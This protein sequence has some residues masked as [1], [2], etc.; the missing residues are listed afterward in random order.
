MTDASSSSVV[1]NCDQKYEN[2]DMD[3]QIQA[4]CKIQ[5]N[6]CDRMANDLWGKIMLGFCLTGRENN[7]KDHLKLVCQV[8]L[9]FIFFEGFHAV[10]TR[11]FIGYINLIKKQIKNEESLVKFKGLKVC[12][13]DVL[14]FSNM[15]ECEFKL[16]FGDDDGN[17]I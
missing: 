16:S 3:K 2:L 15:S 12:E 1:T 13:I 14:T 4:L 7:T 17:V 9:P 10:N 8:R 5:N 6:L 11:Q